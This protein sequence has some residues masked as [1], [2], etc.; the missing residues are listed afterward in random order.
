MKPLELTTDLMRNKENEVSHNS[1]VTTTRGTQ[2]AK[3]PLGALMWSMDSCERD[4]QGTYRF[5]VDRM[6]INLMNSDCKPCLKN[7]HHQGH[8]KCIHSYE[9]AV[10]FKAWY[11]TAVRFLTRLPC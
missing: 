2:L 3:S 8:W 10:R 4:V 6:L 11:G 5:K 9:G 1:K 7:N